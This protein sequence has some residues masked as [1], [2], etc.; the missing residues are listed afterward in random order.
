MNNG[1]ASGPSD[2]TGEMLK[3]SLDRSSEEIAH[4]MNDVF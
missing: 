2:I 4:L 1:K 3:A